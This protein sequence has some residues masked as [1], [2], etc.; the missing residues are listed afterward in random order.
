M[1]SIETLVIFAVAATAFAVVPGPSVIYVVTRSVG[2]GRRA[3]VVSASAM[4]AG[5]L[6]HVGAATMGLSALL[7]SST[8][9]FNAVKYLGA[10]YLIYLGLQAL[11]HGDDAHSPSPNNVQPIRRVFRDGVIVAVLNPKT[12]LFFLAFLPQFV[13]ADR[14]PAAV[15]L[16]VLGLALVAIAF[17]SDA[18]YA[19]ITGCIGD[20]L[21]NR[22]NLLRHSRFITGP[23]YIALGMTALLTGSRPST[24]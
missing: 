20:W 17:V 12:A 10:A 16:V 3:G 6:V 1:P 5:T 11:R 8:A 24:S 2:Q 13:D 4:A 19:A 9:A 23:A 14:G 21:K 7:A 22:T 15:Q 18:T